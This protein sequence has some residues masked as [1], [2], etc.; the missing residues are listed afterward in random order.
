MNFPL[1]FLQ[2]TLIFIQIL[3]NYKTSGQ[4]SVCFCVTTGFCTSNP[5]TPPNDGSNNIDIRIVN[6][7]IFT[8]IYINLQFMTELLSILSLWKN[9]FQ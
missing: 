9:I 4:S 6:V 1:H 5:V 2:A 7:R 3:T 8:R